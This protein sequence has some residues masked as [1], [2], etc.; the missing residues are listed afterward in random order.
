MSVERKDQSFLARKWFWGRRT[1][2]PM[3]LQTTEYSE[4]VRASCWSRLYGCMYRRAQT[5][6]SS[7]TAVERD[8]SLYRQ[9][10]EALRKAFAEDPSLS[11]C[12]SSEGIMLTSRVRNE[13]ESGINTVKPGSASQAEESRSAVG[14]L[15]EVPL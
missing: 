2:K 8:D 1:A 15:Q 4:P 14:A 13:A 9:M 10:S 12:Y 6:D 7:F 11:S 3:S 5:E